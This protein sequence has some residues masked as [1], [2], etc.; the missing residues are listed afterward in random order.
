MLSQHF[1]QTVARR[2]GEEA[3]FAETTPL[4]QQ[5]LRNEALEEE[6]TIRSFFEDL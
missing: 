3:A 4:S 2:N 5:W 1:S 6:D